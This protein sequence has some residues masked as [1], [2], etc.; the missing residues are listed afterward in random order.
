MGFRDDELDILESRTR[1][2]SR[3]A[4]RGEVEPEREGVA[5]TAGGEQYVVDTRAVRGVAALSRITP[6]P[7]QPVHVAGLLSAGGELLPA[8]FLRAVLDQSL[9][10]LP[11]HGR[12]LVCGRARA[13]LAL[14]VDRVLEVRPVAELQPVP[15]SYGPRARRLIGGLC[16][17][18]LPWIDGELLLSSDR[19]VVDIPR[20]SREAL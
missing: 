5:V 1:A 11:E 2:L 14:V 18:G 3:P 10:A 20:P 13:E 12:A 8:F 9:A 6:L 7:R 19:L 16:A 15:E 4:R 17:D